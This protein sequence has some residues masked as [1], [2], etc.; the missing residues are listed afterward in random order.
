MAMHDAQ[1]ACEKL[2]TLVRGSDLN[3]LIQETPY[4][5]FVTIRKSFCREPKNCSNNTFD[6]VCDE[7]LKVENDALKSTLKDTESQLIS[8]KKE[9]ETLQSRLEKAENEILDIIKEEKAAKDKLEEKIAN[10][11]SENKK[12]DELISSLKL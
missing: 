10:L 12:N 4:S 8:R 5:A 2:L 6:E 1:I 3:F 11:I 7:K 9:L